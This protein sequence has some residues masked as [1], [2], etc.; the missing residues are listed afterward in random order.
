VA[1]LSP[2]IEADGVHDDPGRR[3]VRVLE[4]RRRTWRQADR[5]VRALQIEARLS[6]R[7]TLAPYLTLTPYGGNLEGVRAA[8]LSYFGHEPE[9]A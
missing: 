4:P 5:D 3:H 1:V 2:V 6:K 7:E 8:S 9:G